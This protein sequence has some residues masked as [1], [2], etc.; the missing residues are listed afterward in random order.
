MAAEGGAQ[1][2][3]PD[4]CCTGCFL[5]CLQRVEGSKSWC[6]HCQAA[7]QLYSNHPAM[8]G[9]IK[10]KRQIH[11]PIHECCTCR[12]HQTRAHIQ[13]CHSYSKGRQAH[14]AMYGYIKET[15]G[16][17]QPLAAF[18]KGYRPQGRIWK[19]GDLLW[20]E[21]SAEGQECLSG[22]IEVMD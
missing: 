22:P 11:K 17:L 10:E 19:E 15:G 18:L 21:G 8:R 14:G 20:K 5:L 13:P 1:F 7:T 2:S 3:I 12:N 16:L 4:T 6:V 9:S